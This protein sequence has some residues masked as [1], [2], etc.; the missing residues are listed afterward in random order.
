MPICAERQ[1]IYDKIVSITDEI[2]KLSLTIELANLNGSV[3]RNEV[4]EMVEK[5]EKENPKLFNTNAS[6]FIRCYRANGSLK[7][8]G[9][10][11]EFFEY[12][13]EDINPL[14]LLI[15]FL[16]TF[17]RITDYE[18]FCSHHEFCDSLEHFGYNIMA[19]YLRK[20]YIQNSAITE[21]IYK[22]FSA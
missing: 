4:T 16:M 13:P 14:Y 9:K 2:G 5:A 15:L 12:N 22:I 19:D 21:N 17:G 18:I 20:H 1:R 6:E 3:T 11:E 7:I 8:F 10:G